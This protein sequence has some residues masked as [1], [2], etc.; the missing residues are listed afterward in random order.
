MTRNTAIVTK[1]FYQNEKLITV[2]Q[3]TQIKRIFRASYMVTGEINIEASALVKLLATDSSD[4]VLSSSDEHEPRAFTAY[5]YRHSQYPGTNKALLAFN[6][7]RLHSEINGY[8]LGNGARTYL[9]SAMRFSTPDILSPFGAGGIN[10]YA[11]VEGD[12]INYS[13]PSGKFRF[14]TRSKTFSGTARPVEGQFIFMAKHPTIKNK[15]AI[16]V[17]THGAAG[18]IDSAFGGTNAST[19]LRN[20]KKAGFDTNKYD[21]HIIACMSANPTDNQPS[22]IQNISNLTGRT[23]IG[24][25]GYVSTYDT[26]DLSRA[27]QQQVG[28][29]ITVI[30][31]LWSFAKNKSQFNFKR[32]IAQSQ[33]KNRGVRAP[34]PNRY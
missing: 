23:S 21:T 25:Y 26:I 32:V 16:T 8:L 14:F 33:E 29:N 17:V 2:K 28:V 4:S 11:F 31:K 3:D 13:D 34:R 22:F 19:F 30:E 6:G 12:P 5:G 15:R 9:P 1:H 20:I 18:T 27:P 10:S 7:E 24:Y